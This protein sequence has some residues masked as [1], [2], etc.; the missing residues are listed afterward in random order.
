MDRRVENSALN[1]PRSQDLELGS[2]RS[3]RADSLEPDVSSA[4]SSVDGEYYAR[5]QGCTVH[6][7]DEAAAQNPEVEN[8]GDYE[9]F[10][11]L[12]TAESTGK[13]K[14]EELLR[15]CLKVRW[16][17]I[18]EIWLNYGDAY[19]NKRR[20]RARMRWMWVVYFCSFCEVWLKCRQ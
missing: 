11:S 2:R 6:V 16:F 8:S 14:L 5:S 12:T 9:C 13:V 10:A 7:R 19:K 20:D 1:Q 4:R 15:T 17:R 18:Q 3:T